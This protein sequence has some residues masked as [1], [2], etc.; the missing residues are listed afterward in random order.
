MRSFFALATSWRSS[1]SIRRS[2]LKI[3]ARVV[4]KAARI[5]FASACPDATLFRM[6][7][8]RLATSG[9]D[10]QGAVPQEPETVQPPRL[11]AE[12]AEERPE[13]HG[14]EHDDPDPAAS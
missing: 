4:E 6:L 14:D 1:S 11:V 3:G 2:L 12:N 5:H 7:A 9:P 8:G 10:R 13:H